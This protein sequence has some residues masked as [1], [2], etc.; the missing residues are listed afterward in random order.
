M[1]KRKHRGDR[2]EAVPFK[3]KLC[4]ALDIVPD[5]LPGSANVM[6]RGKSAVYIENGGRILSYSPDEIRVSIP[7]GSV[8]ICGRALVC[9]SYMRGNV[10]IDGVITSVYF[11]ES[12]K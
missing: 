11:G 6:I 8:G 9:S 5:T 2:G 12:E 4:D 1:K 3:N 10:R 7:D